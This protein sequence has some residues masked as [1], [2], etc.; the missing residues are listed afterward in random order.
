MSGGGGGGASSSNSS[1]CGRWPT[2]KSGNLFGQL[3]STIT[4]QSGE[5]K[6]VQVDVRHAYCATDLAVDLTPIVEPSTIW[7]VS[8]LLLLLLFF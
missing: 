2:G 3:P 7:T 1:G 5:A 8:L 4:N 6:L